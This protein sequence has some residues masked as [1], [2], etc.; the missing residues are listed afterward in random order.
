MQVYQIW[1][2]ASKSNR[3]NKKCSAYFCG[4]CFYN[5]DYNLILLVYYKSNQSKM[6]PIIKKRWKFWLFLFNQ[7]TKNVYKQSLCL[8]IFCFNMKGMK[9]HRFYMKWSL[10]MIT[11]A[12]I[13]IRINC[14]YIYW[15]SQHALGTWPTWLE[16]AR[17]Y[18]M[19]LTGCQNSTDHLIL[20]S[21]NLS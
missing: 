20:R 19:P 2:N 21:S 4:R 1:I 6:K 18:N 3:L 14:H 15:V 7:Y 9:I 17:F 8:K 11:G 12:F 10:N 13:H 16:L 5:F